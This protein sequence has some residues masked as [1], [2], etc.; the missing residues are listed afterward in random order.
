[1]RG[2]AAALKANRQPLT[3][4]TVYLNKG[5]Y[6]IETQ[7]RRVPQNMPTSLGVQVLSGAKLVM[8]RFYY[9]FLD[10]YLR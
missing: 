6:E 5:V 1:M 8:L 10:Q 2:E 9:D 3:K 7:P 4:K